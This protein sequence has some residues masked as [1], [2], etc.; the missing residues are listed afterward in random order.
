MPSEDFACGAAKSTSDAGTIA[1]VGWKM[2]GTKV[3]YF[4]GPHAVA[5]LAA[6][7]G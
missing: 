1:T 3:V 6:S 7:N 2:H 5:T 4:F